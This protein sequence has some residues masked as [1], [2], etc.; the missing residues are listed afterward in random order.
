MSSNFLREII[1]KKLSVELIKL[2]KDF[3]ELSSLKLCYLL[4]EQRILHQISVWDG[5][6]LD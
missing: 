1:L 6:E 2:A 4:Y 5:D 3:V